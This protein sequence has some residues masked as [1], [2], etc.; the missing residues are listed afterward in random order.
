MLSI[1]HPKCEWCVSNVI[2]WLA[3]LVIALWEVP[4]PWKWFDADGLPACIT[5]DDRPMLDAKNKLPSGSLK[6]PWCQLWLKKQAWGVLSWVYT[7]ECVCLAVL[8]A[9]WWFEDHSFMNLWR[10]WPPHIFCYRLDA[11]ERKGNLPILFWLQLDYVPRAV[12]HFTLY[13]KKVSVPRPNL[14]VL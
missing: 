11:F 1:P 10:F 12:I 8:L 6:S 14:L 3:R 4:Q 7:I 13:L 9:L 2:C 5:T